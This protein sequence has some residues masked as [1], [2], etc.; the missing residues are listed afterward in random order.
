MATLKKLAIKETNQHLILSFIINIH[1]FVK[2]AVWSLRLAS[3]NRKFKSFLLI[4]LPTP[5]KA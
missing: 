4:Q 5:L 2:L 3:L 1:I